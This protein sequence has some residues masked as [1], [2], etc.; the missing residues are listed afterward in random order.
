[1][2][3]NDF[4]DPR[5]I[6]AG[7]GT[8]STIAGWKALADGLL[9]T[10]TCPFHRNVEISARYAWM[11]GL[12]P[13]YLK[14]CGMA[15][16]A[17]HHVRLALYP[18]RLA[19]DCRGVLDIPR[20]L[21][22]PR[23][24]LLADVNTI[25]ETNNGIFDDIFWVHFAYTSADDGI[26]CL[27]AVLGTE[28]AYDAVLAGFELI[29]RGR[30]IQEDPASGPNERAAA[31]EIVWKGNLML[32]EHEQRALVQPQ[33]D[34][35]SCRFARLVSMGSATTFE[36]SGLRHELRYFTSFYWSLARHRGPAASRVRGRP[37]ITAFDDRWR[38]LE[39]GVVPRFRRLDADSSLFDLSLRPI[40]EESLYYT[41]HPCVLRD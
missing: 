7:T 23:A 16:L 1:M 27:R 31:D 29:D 26:R 17:S 28:P 18:L 41:V 25:R 40:R 5:E 10:H 21:G 39:S 20:T 3:I 15:A 8:P 38:W 35:L 24:F 6:V 33:F 22:S 19:T 13:R 37:L 12:L 11:Y 36:V 14:W 4:P 9:T 30:R 34:R 2:L 32:L